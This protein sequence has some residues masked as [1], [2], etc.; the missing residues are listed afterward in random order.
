MSLEVSVK[1]ENILE[2]S[3]KEIEGMCNIVKPF[4]IDEGFRDIF[5]G[6]KYL[7]AM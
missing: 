1:L 5:T 3:L 2:D 7:Y 6:V 4:L